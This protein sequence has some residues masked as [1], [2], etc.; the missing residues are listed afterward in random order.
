MT[1]IYNAEATG[2]GGVGLPQQVADDISAIS[3][4]LFAL[5]LHGSEI[6]ALF[7]LTAR[8]VRAE[9][10][11]T[12]DLDLLSVLGLAV[13]ELHR[14]LP[15]PRTLGAA[16]LER[17]LERL[18]DAVAAVHQQALDAADEDDG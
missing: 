15:P 8:L 9:R 14:E 18:T 1:V 4:H 7:R 2:R 5:G 16:A 13:D 10:H 11:W 12:A 17:R 3:S 6:A